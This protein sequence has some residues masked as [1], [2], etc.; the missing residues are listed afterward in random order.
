MNQ[1][2]TDI[3]HQHH[4][5]VVCKE[6]SG[7]LR[8]GHNPHSQSDVIKKHNNSM[9]ILQRN[10]MITSNDASLYIVM[11]CRR[12]EDFYIYTDL[13]LLDKRKCKSNQLSES[14]EIRTKA[15][16]KTKTSCEKLI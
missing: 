16:I 2:S 4:V 11:C 8:W 12:N 5:P 9:E 1:Q 10:N 15:K 13:K 3:S 7:E 14:G 6:I